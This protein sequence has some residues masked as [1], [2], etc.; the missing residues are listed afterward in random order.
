MS[1]ASPSLAA[2]RCSPLALMILPASR[3]RLR[4]DVPSPAACS[5]EAG[6]SELDQGDFDPP[7]SGGAIEDHADVLVDPIGLFQDLVKCVLIDDVAKRGLSDLVDRCAD[8]LDR[9]H[10]P[11]GSTT[12]K[13]RRN[14]A[15][16]GHRSSSSRV[17]MAFWWRRHPS[18]SLCP[19]SSRARAQAARSRAPRAPWPG[20]LSRQA[21]HRSTTVSTASTSAASEQ[22][23]SLSLSALY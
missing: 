18:T 6:C 11:H 13:G 2:A 5:R 15:V 20:H 8:V 9:D 23:A 12:G 14:S 19:L 22:K 21:R 3:A 4:L 1:D 10:G 17:S 7:L 16:A